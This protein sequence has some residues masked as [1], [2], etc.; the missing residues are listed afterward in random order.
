MIALR[1]M[2]E[3]R[4]DG[5]P[6]LA[7]LRSDLASVTKS[8]RHDALAG[9]WVVVRSRSTP[10]FDDDWGLAGPFGYGG[11]STEWFEGFVPLPGD[12]TYSP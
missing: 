10:D 11:L 1:P 7:K 4:K 6:V 8:G 5:T 12:N 3:A 2:T 9:L